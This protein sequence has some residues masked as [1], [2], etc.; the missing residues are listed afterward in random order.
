MKKDH[1][2]Y[3]YYRCKIRLYN[4]VYGDIFKEGGEVRQQIE[5]LIY[6]AFLYDDLLLYSDF[7]EGIILYL[8]IKLLNV[9]ICIVKQLEIEE[10]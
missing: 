4:E 6:F 1:E 3:S 5:V 8:F 7:R 2:Y 10:I 9:V